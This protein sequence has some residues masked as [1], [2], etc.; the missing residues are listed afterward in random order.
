[1]L[2]V[3]PD[4]FNIDSYRVI[5]RDRQQGDRI[6]VRKIELD[7]LCVA[8]GPERRLSSG[9]RCK[10]Q[11]RR[12]SLHISAQYF[13]QEHSRQDESLPIFRAVKARRA[14]QLIGRH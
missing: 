9:G 8:A 14:L 12:I 3:A 2:E 4:A 1:V 10:L 6:G 13:A 11:I 7:R 5:S